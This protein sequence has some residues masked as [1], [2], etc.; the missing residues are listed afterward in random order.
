MKIFSQF[1]ESLKSLG[2]ADRR[3]ILGIS[4]GPVT[5]DK[6]ASRSKLDVDEINLDACDEALTILSRRFEFGGGLPPL[7]LDRMSSPETADLCLEWLISS[8][9]SSLSV[10][11][12]VERIRVA[13]SAGA[14]RSYVPNFPGPA[15][16]RWHMVEEILSRP[17]DFPRSLVVLATR[18]VLRRKT[19]YKPVSKVAIDDGWFED[20]ADRARLRP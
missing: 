14:S 19:S 13:Y 8:R 10:D 6:A 7:L 4:A 3:S 9:A 16:R 18:A 1:D 2:Q 5:Y 20:E 15:A 17:W 11:E 12:L